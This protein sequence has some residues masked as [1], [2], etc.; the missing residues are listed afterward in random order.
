MSGISNTSDYLLFYGSL[1]QGLDGRQKLNIEAFIEYL[2]NCRV[3][4]RLYDLGPY[5][6]LLLSEAGQVVCELYHIK[7]A[8][9]IALLDAFEDFDPRNQA[10]SLYLRKRIPVPGHH[11][12]AW[13]YEYN[14]P[15]RPDQ[16]ITSGDWKNPR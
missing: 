8:Q 4:G 2:S 11:L 3:P 13:I 12:E 15:V 14:R 10:A 1:R 6:G 16:F 5:P 7:D 9:C